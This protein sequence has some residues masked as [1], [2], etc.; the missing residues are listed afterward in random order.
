MLTER[1][2]GRPRKFSL[3]QY[4]EADHINGDQ[5]RTKRGLRNK[6][7][8]MKGFAVGQ[9]LIAEGHNIDSIMNPVEQ[10][11]AW[12]I[13]REVGQ[14]PEHER[15]D[16]ILYICEAEKQEHKTVR[17]WAEILKRARLEVFR[18]TVSQNTISEVAA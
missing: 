11:A 17:Q 13:L 8:E 2:R 18:E 9:K 4:A 3:A 12:G 15:A 16:I 5:V 10:K 1:K 14:Q 7:H 6:M